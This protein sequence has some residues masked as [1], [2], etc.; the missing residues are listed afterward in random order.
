MVK[1]IDSSLDKANHLH[2]LL[3]DPN[4]PLIAGWKEG[5]KGMREG[6]KKR[7]FY[8]LL[9]RLWRKRIGAYSCKI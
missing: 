3:D 4:L 5:V 9:F 6:D 8:S 1:K 2:L 7:S